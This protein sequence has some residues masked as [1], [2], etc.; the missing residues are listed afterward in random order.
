MDDPASTPEFARIDA[1]TIGGEG[2][3]AL[4]TGWLTAA[5]T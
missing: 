4:H 3:A 2:L 1:M 5:F